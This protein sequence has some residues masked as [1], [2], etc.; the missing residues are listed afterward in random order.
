MG[1]C[2]L[3]LYVRPIPTNSVRAV[4]PDHFGL[5]DEVSWAPRWNIAPTQQIPIV[6][7]DNKQP[8]GRLP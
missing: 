3:P 7:Q 4:Y 8:K 1:L 2:D 6:R 5:E